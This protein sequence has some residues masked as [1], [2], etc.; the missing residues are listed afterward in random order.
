MSSRPSHSQTQA[1]PPDY[2]GQRLDN[3]LIRILR[4]LPRA[5]VY[6]LIRTGQIRV[7]GKRAKP[8]AR[9]RPNDQIRIPPQTPTRPTRPTP[10]TLSAP[11]IRTREKQ[12]PLPPVILEDDRL[13][14]VDKP[15]GLAVHGGSGT[16]FGVIERFRAARPGAY[17]E[18]AHRLDRGASGVLVLAKKPS[19]LRDLQRQWRA[20]EVGKEYVIACFGEWKKSA[21][22]I[23]APLRRVAAPDGNRQV[24]PDS[25][26]GR[27]AETRAK[28][29]QQWNGAA[30]IR[31]EIKTGRTHQLR[32]HMAHPELAGLPIV[33]DDKY[34]DFRRNKELPPGLRGR[35]FLHAC[36]LVFRH[37]STGGEMSAEAPLPPEFA[38]LREFFS[39]RPYMPVGG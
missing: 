17:L 10:P 37:P 31:A 21:A 26:L 28:L 32:A 24:V 22:R 1:V 27:P 11:S 16:A 23:S 6:R 19:A 38:E 14:I 18:L 34:G 15:S 2:D 36:R 30:L 7:N 25:E 9:L 8:L 12:H 20:R 13:L 4:P 5:A 35:L 29:S 39:R 3:F 33:G